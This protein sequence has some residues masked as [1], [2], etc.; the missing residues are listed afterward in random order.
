MDLRLAAVEFR[1]AEIL[2]QSTPVTTKELVAICSKELNWARTTTY[3]VLRKLCLRGIFETKDGVVTTLIAK[4][5]YHAIRSEQFINK[6]FGG[7]LPA[8]MAAFVSRQQP[9]KEDLTR[10][11]ELVNEIGD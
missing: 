10:L 7:S 2:W 4:D 11:K 9:S 8:F 5:E 3:T 1:F 6:D